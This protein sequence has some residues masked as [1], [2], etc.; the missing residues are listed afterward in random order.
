MKKTDE[1]ILNSLRQEFEKSAET[2]NVP[3][4]LQKESIVA[5]LKD[6]NIQKD[7]SD[8]T[9]TETKK[10]NEN[11][12]ILRRLT[13]V[14]AMLAI[15]VSGTLALRADNVRMTKVDTF[16]ENNESQDQIK[17]V[18]NDRELEDVINEIISKNSSQQAAASPNQQG[19]QQSVK[20]ETDG[21][22]H[23]GITAPTAPAVTAAQSTATSA[24]GNYDNL[25]AV[26]E[27]IGSDAGIF[28][29]SHI[30]SNS[31]G[32]T[33]RDGYEADIVKQDGKFLY[34][35]SFGTNQGNGGIIEEIKIVKTLPAEEMQVVS[36][37][38]LTEYS[39]AETVDKCLEIHVKDGKLIALISRTDS[40]TK[41]TST[42]AAFYDISVPE[43]PVKIREHIQ[44]GAYVSSSLQ[45]NNLCLVT[46]K[47]VT[48]T[49][50]TVIPSFSVDGKAI[51]LDAKSEI[52]IVNDPDTSY[53]F[54]TVTD[55]SDF[56]RSV[57]RMAIIGCGKKLYCTSA[58][59]AF[60][61][62]FVSTQADEQGVYSTK[63]EICRFNISGSSISFGGSQLVD[64]SLVG[65]LSVD[66]SN[67]YLRAVTAVG[68]S[69]NIYVFGENM[70]IVSANSIEHK[71]QNAIGS[72][73]IGSNGYIVVSGENGEQTMIIDLSKPEKPK[74]AGKIATEGFSDS[75]YMISDTLILGIKSEK[76]FLEKEILDGN[77]NTEKAETESDLVTFTL[78]DISDPYNPKICDTYP[79]KD[80][81]TTVV[82]S[83]DGKGIIIIPDK[84]MFGVPVKVY[85]EETKTESSEYMIFDVS[86]GSF[87][88]AAVKYFTHS[89]TV[90]GNAASRGACIDDVLYTVSGDEIV[91]FSIADG[92]EIARSEII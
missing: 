53:I 1:Q 76:V 84:N 69:S 28:G 33:A 56:S 27:E 52:F 41:S 82:S 29:T 55:I 70:E 73:F 2:A 24:I 40:A 12:I 61:R 17:N 85:N 74:G 81:N 8:K 71:G 14:A 92:S 7:F 22:T 26:K 80:I 86:H 18:R 11:I 65:G 21:A 25:V 32:V 36:S 75:L 90:I 88:D 87:D 51:G 16:N 49:A 67:G 54:I 34:V 83:E 3:L 89:E 31:S 57:G 5:M 50:D 48:D 9:G 60:A 47:T 38:K 39:S 45:G 4:R 58:S 77:G 6:E 78:F 72:M 59:V 35:V 30:F 62:E 79:V 64:G 13:A 68:S 19:S 15:I 66:E 63:T 44:D 91:A 46:D 10:K 43:N 42:V 23:G 20:Q 37:V